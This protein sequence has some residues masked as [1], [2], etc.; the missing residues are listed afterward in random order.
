LRCPLCGTVVRADDALGLTEGR[1]AHAECAL[2]H[3]LEHDR[4]PSAAGAGTAGAANEASA[5]PGRELH[6]L[7]AAVLN[8]HT[9]QPDA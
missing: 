4:S 9:Q 8:G 6:A 1:L 7:I 2:A 5:S 3:W